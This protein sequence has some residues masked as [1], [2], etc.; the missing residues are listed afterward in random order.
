M[1]ITLH[2]CTQPPASYW[3]FSVKVFIPQLGPLMKCQPRQK[4]SAFSSYTTSFDSGEIINL[5]MC[6]ICNFMQSWFILVLK[7][8]VA[9]QGGSA[10]LH[11]YFTN[12]ALICAV[13]VSCW[14][15]C[16][17][18]LFFQTNPDLRLQQVPQHTHLGV[19]AVTLGLCYPQVS[20]KHCSSQPVLSETTIQGRIA[21]I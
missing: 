7:Y 21:N 12:R 5:F 11:F 1:I 13:M 8:K 19:S 6:L 4:Q 9:P 20:V 3:L 16:S 14:H 2:F 15:M 18:T 10:D 17:R